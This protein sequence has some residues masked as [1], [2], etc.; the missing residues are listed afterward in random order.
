MR[1]CC[2]LDCPCGWWA[3]I[4]RSACVWGLRATSAAVTVLLPRVAPFPNPFGDPLPSQ[5]IGFYH[6]TYQSV[7]QGSPAVR[8]YGLMWCNYGIAI[9]ESKPTIVMQ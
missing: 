2:R 7:R 8:A 1:R 3:A 6:G 4:W 9:W 5:S